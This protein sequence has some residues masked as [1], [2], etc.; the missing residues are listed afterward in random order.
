MLRKLGLLM[1]L[2]VICFMMS[3]S[4]DDP[5]DH[6]LRVRNNLPATIL[7][8]TLTLD[9]TVGSL[10]FEDVEPGGTTAY[11]DI[12]EGTHSVS[13]TMTVEGQTVPLLTGSIS[14]QGD[15][16]HHWTMIIEADG[17]EVVED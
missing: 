15:G 11:Q 7:P 13:G 9:V 12:G 10:V 4:S 6:K 16:E 2:V 8:A 17:V 1:F 3:C 5:P 14:I